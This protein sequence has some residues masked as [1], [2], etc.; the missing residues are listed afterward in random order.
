MMVLFF[1]QDYSIYNLFF[2]EITGLLNQ[3]VNLK[4]VLLKREVRFKFYEKAFSV[5]SLIYWEDLDLIKRF[6]LLCEA[7]ILHFEMLR[8]IVPVLPYVFLF[9]KKCTLTVHGWVSTSGGLISTLLQIPFQGFNRVWV[10]NKSDVLVLS[11]LKNVERLNDMGFGVK[12][13][14]FFTVKDFVHDDL[15]GLFVGRW[16]ELKGFHLLPDFLYN[17]ER[18]GIYFK[19]FFILGNIDK[20]RESKLV[21]GAI[22]RLLK[23]NYVEFIGSTDDLKKYYNQVQFVVLPSNREGISIAMSEAI[24]NQKYLITYGCRGVRELLPDRYTVPFEFWGDTSKLAGLVENFLLNEKFSQ[25][26]LNY[27]CSRKELLNRDSCASEISL[28]YLKNWKKNEQ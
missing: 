4:V 19:K 28:I 22:E 6:K 13:E 17:C 23:F 27:F 1:V 5:N 26:Y 18:R 7:N 25:D 10:L 9:R 24:V 3:S 2:A 11:S 14:R 12:R 16:N 15:G 8:S 21:N 20:L